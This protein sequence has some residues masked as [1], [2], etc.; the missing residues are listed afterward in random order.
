MLK[1]PTEN[2]SS[3]KQC[4]ILRSPPNSWNDLCG[5]LAGPMHEVD[6]FRACIE[7]FQLEPFVVA[8]GPPERPRALAPLAL[9]RGRLE[10]VGV[11]QLSEPMDFLAEDEAAATELAEAIAGLGRPLLLQRIPTLSPVIPALRRIWRRA[12]WIECPMSSCPVLALDKTWTDPESH[13]SSRRRA[14]FRR[15]RKRT[16]RV[17]AEILIPTAD[18]TPILV[19]TALKIERRSWKG[20]NGTS[21]L[22]LPGRADFFRRYCQMKA[23]DGTLRLA[24]LKIGGEYAA[25]QIAVERDNAYWLLKIGYDER[26]ARCSPGQ[27]LISHSIGWAAA[28][29]LL[30]YEFL[31]K[32]EGWISLW[33]QCRRPCV[34]IGVY[35]P[36]VASIR[37]ALR[38]ARDLV[39]WKLRQRRRVE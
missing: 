33:T 32:A 2:W 4:T 14:D 10:A 17:E 26:F 27:L 35:P 23:A 31:G 5:S 19:E 18:E 3:A 12:V 38:D 37:G 28:R 16:E 22:Q 24:F 8:I 30:S 6:W 7:A 34:A 13:L 21:A 11:R 9:V 25:M 39:A 15:A 36:R 29:G 20:R 1:A